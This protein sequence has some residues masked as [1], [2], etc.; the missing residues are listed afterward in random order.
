M[1]PVVRGERETRKQILIYSVE[2]VVLTL[3]GP[4][5]GIGGV[6]YFI[7]AAVLG[8]ILLYMAGNL[9]AQGYNAK[10][11]YRT[12]RYTSMYLAFIFLVMVVDALI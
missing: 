11:A 8:L 1:M 12:Y 2:L 10:L 5:V 3:L 9:W 4:L 7:S 6:I